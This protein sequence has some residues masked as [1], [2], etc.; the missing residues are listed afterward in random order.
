M[1]IQAVIWDMD[2]VI[3]DSEVYWLQSREEF[4][5]DLGKGWTDSDQRKC[6]GR[7]TIEWAQVMQ[8][9]LSTTMTL[10]EIMADMIARV[11][12]HYE[13]RMPARPGALEAVRLSAANYRV[14]LASGS[15]T[16]VIDHVLKLT[17][18]DK[19]FETV[20]YGDDM[21]HG[22]PA[23]DIYIETMKRLNVTPE[24]SI[25]IEDSGNGIRSLKA[26]KMFAIA[27]P[28]PAFPLSNEV[29]ELA[30]AHISSL[31]EFSLDLVRRVGG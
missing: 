29:L 18:L 21:E 11:M 8:E 1:A 3:V 25:G 6:M 28:S 16:A 2:G 27:A 10:D 23:P 14:A 4:A 22:K 26:A 17:G 30:D 24:V 5:R 13:E 7:S 31:E 19:V 9:I 20:V 15:P 12:R